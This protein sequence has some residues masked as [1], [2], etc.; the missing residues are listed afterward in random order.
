MECTLLPQCHAPLF[1]KLISLS[2]FKKG[3]LGG[4]QVHN[5]AEICIVSQGMMSHADNEERNKI[6]ANFELCHQTAI[7]HGVV[8]VKSICK[9]G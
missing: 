2:I 9:S 7:E 3:S 6:Q 8:R 4:I 5:L 1:T